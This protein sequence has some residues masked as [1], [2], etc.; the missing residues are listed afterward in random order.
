[1]TPG[2]RIRHGNHDLLIVRQAQDQ[3]ACLLGSSVVEL[4]GSAYPVTE[5]RELPCALTI[6]SYRMPDF[7]EL[8]IVMSRLVY[9]PSIPIL[10]SDDQSSE[11]GKIEAVAAKHGCHYLCTTGRMAHCGGDIQHFINAA[12]FARQE[13]RPFAIKHSCRF[14]PL[15]G[16]EQLWFDG[17]RKHGLVLPGQIQQNQIARPDARFYTKFGILTDVAGWKTGSLTGEDIANH[18][19]EGCA[20][21]KHAFD[22]FVEIAWGKLAGIK[23]PGA[24]LIEP[25]LANHEIGKPKLY[26]RKAQSGRQEYQRVAELLEIEGSFDIREWKAIEGGSYKCFASKL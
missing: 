25:R 18:Y 13:E 6:G 3:S 26:L 20:N 19:R 2:T 23:F 12:E 24:H 17:L 10:V 1:M 22:N 21:A 15:A 5:V 8:N 14:I 9:G 11:S 16:L 7:V 4:P